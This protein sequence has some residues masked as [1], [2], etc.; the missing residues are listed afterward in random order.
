[1]LI[2]IETPGGGGGECE[3]KFLG[4][5]LQLPNL[6]SFPYYPVFKLSFLTI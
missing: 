4:T 5:I 2:K 1:M 3:V 6:F